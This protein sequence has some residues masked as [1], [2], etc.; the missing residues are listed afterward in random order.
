MEYFFNKESKAIVLK[1]DDDIHV[2]GKTFK[3]SYVPADEAYFITSPNQTFKGHLLK[4]DI[5]KR[6]FV[7][8]ING[9]R[10]ELQ[11]ERPIDNQLR[12]MGFDSG[13]AGKISNLKAPMPGLVKKIHVQI[14][15]TIQ[16]GDILLTLEAMKMENIIKAN[17]VGTVKHILVNAFNTVEKNQLLIEFE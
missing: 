14:G 10:I 15:D 4:A 2:D 5:E 11:I 13:G 6:H 12:K 17:A 1:M 16:K 7:F 8:L 9:K 3:V